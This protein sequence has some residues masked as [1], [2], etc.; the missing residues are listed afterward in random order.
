MGHVMGH[1]SRDGWLLL[2][3]RGLRMFGY[4]YVSVVLGL[5]LRAVGFSDVAVGLLLGAALGGTAL[6]TIAWTLLADRVGRRR[7]LLVTSALMCAGG[8][9]FATGDSAW[10]FVLAALTG[11]IT[12]SRAELGVF[13][14][15]DQAVLPATAR[16][17]TQ[18]TWLFSAY[19][20]IGAAAGAA[21]ALFAGATDLL[22]GMGLSETDAFRVLF[23]AYAAIG[24]ANLLL[25]AG[26]SEAVEE[27]ASPG[28]RFS[29]VHRSRGIVLRLAGLFAVDAFAGGF[30]VQAL[31]A[32]WFALRWGLEPGA[33][34]LLFFAAGVLSAASFA[35][36]GWLAGRIGL[37]NT[38]VFSHLPSNAFLI[39]VPLAPTAPLAAV[40]F[41][42]RSALS[43]MDVPTRQSYTM[44]MVDPDERMATA[45]IAN[46]VRSLAAIG[47][48]M[49]AGV[50]FGTAAVGAP[51]V[52]AGG[53]K[54]A[55][56]LAL[57]RMLRPVRLPEDL[58]GD[59]DHGDHG[60]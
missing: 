35:G 41:L 36:A 21:G 49:L 33:L 59:G 15:I 2:V 56:D 57:Y 12:P 27:G 3:A 11:T 58:L 20:L 8:I 54:I 52:I 40:A 32:Y 26:L 51:F 50:A 43:Q 60:R 13:T 34:G 10:V 6:M 47:S 24:L 9:L 18:R 17:A 37:L 31:V 46:V 25:F 14:T 48:P 16:S 42:A 44:A 53:L 28:R 39:L 19:G 29:G 30:V 1:V 55:Y 38:M 5:Y 23:G 7:T 22:A 45:G 4:G